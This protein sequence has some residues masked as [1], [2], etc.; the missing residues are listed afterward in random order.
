MLT[1]G[2]FIARP[3]KNVNILTLAPASPAVTRTPV[4]KPMLTD[5]GERDSGVKTL[6]PRRHNRNPLN[7]DSGLP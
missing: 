2:S 4:E 7:P 1:C 6:D 3:D 5:Y